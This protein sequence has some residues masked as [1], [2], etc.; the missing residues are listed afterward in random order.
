[1]KCQ[2]CGI[3][4]SDEDRA[5]P[6]C[7]ARAGSRGRVG[8]LE[9]KAAA[10]R[11]SQSAERGGTVPPL[12]KKRPQKAKPSARPIRETPKGKGKGKAAV[13]VAAVI[14]V[15]NFLPAV[16]PLFETW[17]D[18]LGEQLPEIFA[19]RE[20]TVSAEAEVWGEYDD[21]AIYYTPGESYAHDPDNYVAVYA[22]LYDLTGGHVTAP[23]GDGIAVE[24]TCEPGDMSNYT[25]TIQDG[26][27]TYTET[28]YS[29]CMYNYPEEGWYD[30]AY[31]PES[32]DSLSL[33][34]TR[35]W[36][37]YDGS[38]PERYDY[39]TANDD[40]WLLLYV[41]RTNYALTLHDID[42]SGLFGQTFVPLVRVEQG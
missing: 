21:N 41:D 38:L 40:L 35:E 14:F 20:E 10:W 37:D 19:Q 16:M 36:S 39:R 27:G 29:W 13:I 33:C 22:T 17:F 2:H 6:I 8:E 32:Y 15:L 30:E 28:G 25:L 34:L 3:N 4:F 31:P 11:E 23:L 7:G 26:T 1:M 9:K 42:D 18:E 5:C 12:F 24:L